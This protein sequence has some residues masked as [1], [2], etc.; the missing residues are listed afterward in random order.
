MFA[1][2]AIMVLLTVLLAPSLVVL[3]LSNRLTVAQAVRT[4]WCVW[5]TQVI[6]SIALI[7]LADTLGLLNPAGYTLGIC[8]LVGLAGAFFLRHQNQT[9]PLS[10]SN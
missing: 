8:A 3:L 9:R 5:A 6:A 2:I 7:V 10:E 1:A 4:G